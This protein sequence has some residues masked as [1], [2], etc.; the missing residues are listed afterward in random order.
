MKSYIWQDEKVPKHRSFFSHGV[1]ECIT[2]LATECIHQPRRSSPFILWRFFFYKQDRIR[3]LTTGGYPQP[4]F[5]PWKLTVRWGWKFQPTNH[6]ISYHGNLPILGCQ[7][8]RMLSR[9]CLG[10]LSYSHLISIKFGLLEKGLLW[11]KYYIPFTTL[12]R[13]STKILE[14]R[15]SVPRTGDK[16]HI[17]TYIY[18]HTSQSVLLV[19]FFL[20]FY[21]SPFPHF[22]LFFLF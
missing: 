18:L 19:I 2:L 8:P 21:F 15:N 4:L 22:F 14:I 16:D 12:L 17:Y 1:W 11:I 20:F 7:L 9:G 3:S 5:P 10:A 6:M 13:N